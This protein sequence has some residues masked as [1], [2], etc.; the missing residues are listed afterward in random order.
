MPSV[1]DDQVV[2]TV[3]AVPA[4]SMT[5]RGYRTAVV[6]TDIVD[7]NGDSP[8]GPDKSGGD[9]TSSRNSKRKRTQS[10]GHIQRAPP[11]VLYAKVGF[12]C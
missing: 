9:V 4:H 10:D 7:A 11:P 2:A 5:P 8:R 3:E 1:S 6:V 12:N